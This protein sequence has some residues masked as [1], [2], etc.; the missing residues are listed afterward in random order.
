MVL[1][2]G[3]VTISKINTENFGEFKGGD[4]NTCL[5]YSSHQKPQHPQSNP[6]Y[7]HLG[8]DWPPLGI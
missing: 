4:L 8:H 3:L 5:G 7:S 2:L 1:S 6:T